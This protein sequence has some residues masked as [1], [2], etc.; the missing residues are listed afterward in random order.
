MERITCTEYRAEKRVSYIFSM[1]IS[2]HHPISETPIVAELMGGIGCLGVW[3][4]FTTGFQKAS[5]RLYNTIILALQGLFVVL[6][7]I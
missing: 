3:L 7:W 5:R 2:K 4:P 1:S 6:R